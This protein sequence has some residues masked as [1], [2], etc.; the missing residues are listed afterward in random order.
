MQAYIIYTVPSNLYIAGTFKRST[1]Q[2][3]ETL[4]HE[5]ETNQAKSEGWFIAVQLQKQS[6]KTSLTASCS[7]QELGGF[8]DDSWEASSFQCL[9][10]ELKAFSLHL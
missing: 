6:T 8:W 5:T 3:V 2:V 7:T 9:P 10:G 4:W 1:F